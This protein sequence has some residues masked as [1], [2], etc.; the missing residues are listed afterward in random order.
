[1]FGLGC[2]ALGTYQGAHTSCPSSVI[3]G[4][5]LTLHGTVKRP[6]EQWFSALLCIRATQ[7]AF[8]E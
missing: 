2:V 4:Q 5:Q 8:P 7:E 6:Q 1:M 3:W